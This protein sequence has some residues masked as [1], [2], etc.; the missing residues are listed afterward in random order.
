MNYSQISEIV[1][2]FWS[3][4]GYLKEK[5]EQESE[6]DKRIRDRIIEFWRW[7][8]KNRGMIKDKLK[9]NYGKLLSH[10]SRLTVLLEK[11]DSETSQ[12]LLLSAPFVGEEF[13]SS[14]FIEYLDKFNDQESIKYISKIFLE[15]L[16]THTPWYKEENII[17]IVEKIYNLGNKSDADKICNIYGSRGHEFLRPIYD[18]FNT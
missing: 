18:E 6:E 17:S 16:S 11:I 14:F 9:G 7:V 4:A 8:Y 5:V 2:F 12:W 1:D 15:M 13:N 3:Q 10:L